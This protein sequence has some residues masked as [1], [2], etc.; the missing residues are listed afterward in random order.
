M[1]VHSPDSFKWTKDIQIIFFSGAEKKE[2][3][4]VK[5][6]EKP[7]SPRILEQFA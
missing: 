6:I 7:S 5:A 4:H 1:F 2:T 3:D